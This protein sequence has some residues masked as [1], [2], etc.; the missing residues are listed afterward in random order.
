MAEPNHPP[1]VA[2]GAP[3]EVVR[4]SALGMCFGVADAL[5]AME[6]I[7]GRTATIHGE[8]VH[9]DEVL[10]R[11]SGRGFRQNAEDARDV[12]PSTPR[13]VITAHGISERERQRLIDAGKELLDT[14]CP[15]VRKAHRAA[16]QLAAEGRLV[17]VVGKRDHVEVRGL[18]GDLDRYE[19][20][21]GVED[22]RA[23][24]ETMLGVVCQTTTA[25]DDLERVVAAIRAANPGADLRFVDTVCEPTRARQ[26]AVQQLIATCDRVV[27]VGGRNSNNTAQLARRCIAAGVPA[28]H[29]QGPEDLDPEWLSGAHRVGL[30]AG[31]STLE[32]TVDAVEDRLRQILDDLVLEERGAPP[33]P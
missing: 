4:A 24:E 27:V 30:T 5:A 8:L 13:V 11:L 2:A 15:L 17:L 14:T 10:Q 21:S 23:Y 1:A 28:V 33:R 7:D 12:V 18:V 6:G 20:V 26:R 19:I 25:D 29:V 3:A 31:T 32:A 22:V 9:N 16:V